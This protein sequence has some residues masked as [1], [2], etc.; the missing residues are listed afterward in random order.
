MLLIAVWP[1]GN[2]TLRDVPVTRARQRHSGTAPEGFVGEL[3]HPSLWGERP[4]PPT[5]HERRQPLAPDPPAVSDEPGP[6]APNPEPDP[7]AL[8]PPAPML[9]I[10]SYSGWPM[11]ASRGAPTRIVRRFDATAPRRAVERELRRRD[12]E[13]GLDLAGAGLIATRLASAVRGHTP[14]VS[15]ATFVAHVSRHGEVTS[16]T[17]RSFS[18]GERDGWVAAATEAHEALV[19]TKL[20]LPGHLKDGAHVT[21]RVTQDTEHPS[22][23]GRKPRR[24]KTIVFEKDPVWRFSP[25]P[26]RKSWREEP[27]V[28]VK[29]NLPPDLKGLG[30]P[31]T[32]LPP[33]NVDGSGCNYLPGD[34]A[35]IGTSAARIVRTYVAVAPAPPIGP[36][37]GT[38]Q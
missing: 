10:W 33:C 17:L 18:G 3:A 12:A 7:L 6:L 1:T 38:R 25:K 23:D 20:N 11:P 30:D 29:D 15:V 8:P 28:S 19:G 2:D 24:K 27:L 9:P 14:P 37:R 16:V 34:L 13:L 4:T 22:G 32:M 31:E 35:D 21:I 26:G 5:V 36:R